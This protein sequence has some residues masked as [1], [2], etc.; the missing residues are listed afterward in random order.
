[1]VNNKENEAK[2]EWSNLM[3]NAARERR[4]LLELGGRL[5]AFGVAVR[6]R[7]NSQE[8]VYQVTI[9]MARYDEQETMMLVKAVGPEGPLLAFHAARLPVDCITSYPGRLAAG[10]V[11]WK[12]DD[13]PPDKYDE[14]SKYLQKRA[15]YLRERGW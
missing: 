8:H 11:R 4:L 15:E 13:Y 2:E 5:E 6:L 10:K 9:K 1:M 7:A 14:I 12:A 3:D